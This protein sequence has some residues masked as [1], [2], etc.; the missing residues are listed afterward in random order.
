MVAAAAITVGLVMSQS[1][2]QGPA[3][4]PT[5]QPVPKATQTATPT[6][7]AGVPAKRATATLPGVAPATHRPSG[8]ATRTSK[9]AE[10]AGTATVG[11]L[12]QNQGG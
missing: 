10:P 7:T 6:A 1:S 8:T 3:A 9:A 11:Q 12:T 2:G 4:K 5:A